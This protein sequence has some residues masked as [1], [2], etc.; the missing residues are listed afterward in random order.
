MDRARR[1]ALAALFVACSL[2]SLAGI[3]EKTMSH[4]ASLVAG[5]G[6]PPSSLLI[7]EIQTGGVSASDEFI[8]LT[9]VGP[10]ATDLAGLEVIYVTASGSTVTRK[11]TWTETRLVDPG[12]HFLLANVAGA[13]GPI[14]DATYSGGIASTGGA[15]ALRPVGGAAVDAVGWG[16]ATNAFVEGS[17]VAAPPAGSSIE[18][19]PGGVAGNGADSNDNAAD[20]FVQPISSPQNLASVAA[21]DASAPPVPIPSPTPTP[22]P[23]AT[24]VATP[25]PSA[26]PTP[27]PTPTPTSS[28]PSPSPTPSPVATSSPSPTAPPLVIS[29]DDARR[30]PIGS[31]VTVVGVITIEPGRL[32]LPNVA[33]IQDATAGI[34]VRLPESLSTSRR[35]TRIQL[36][37]VLAE[38]YGQREL[39]SLTSVI[40]LG[41]APMPAALAVHLAGETVEGRL[42]TVSGTVVTAV[43][44]ST[45]GD[46]AFDLD[47]DGVRIRIVADASSGLARTAFVRRAS[48]RLAGVVGQHAT[49][50]GRLDGYRIWL[51]DGRDVER[52]DAAA[53]PKPTVP[54]PSSRPTPGP[55]GTPAA[56]SIARARLTHDQVVSVE[57]RVTAP[58]T[59]LDPTGRRVVIQDAT[60]AIEV[61]LPSGTTPPAIGARLAVDGTVLRAYGAPRVRATAVRH[62]G[63]GAAPAPASLS[64]APGAGNE[65]RL[66]RIVGIV[67]TVHRLGDRWRA[68]L[69]VGR[70]RV[71]IAGLSGAR[72]ASTA[73]VEGRRASVVGIVRRAYPGAN[74]RRFAIVPRSVA[75]V[76]LGAVAVAPPGGAPDMP[77]GLTG[78]VSAAATAYAALDVDIADLAD[79]VG[80]RVRVGGLIVEVRSD[81]ARLDDATATGRVILSGSAAEYATLLE[82][83]DAV[84]A[85]GIV[86]RRGK[87]LVV[88]VSDAAGLARVGE[89][90]PASPLVESA[91]P[92]F[93]LAPDS[94]DRSARDQRIAATAGPFGS[95]GVPGAAGLVSLLL[96]SVVSAVVTVLRRRHVRR[97]VTSAV[98]SRVGTIRRRERPVD[99]PEPTGPPP[100]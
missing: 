69:V 52:L 51:R 16:D 96:L 42:V 9:N 44:R 6:W 83:G 50:K 60:A 80:Q 88:V 53:T 62:L 24:A 97:R 27:L 87:E 13:F 79:H 54:N 74:D 19:R 14:G 5:V 33:A 70:D 39:R 93:A 1:A 55:S 36:T 7:S 10:A 30:G 23:T 12:R 45:S 41:D 59:L 81:G 65:W 38:P 8:E 89:L 92:S 43:A 47:A 77:H 29:I 71:P 56:T 15:I 78:G 82:Q 4:A 11:A 32:G 22:A 2:S 26:T 40:A 3:D 17:A 99:I 49:A 20:F 61:L 37:G 48:Y 46:L 35:G 100:M 66:V 68:E 95:R 18:R 58:A 67:D 34:A 85:T 84:N 94:E 64:G 21:T 72:I 73:L 91:N 31:V 76:D 25:T 75:D 86:E 90:D 63:S 28:A 98:A 57:G